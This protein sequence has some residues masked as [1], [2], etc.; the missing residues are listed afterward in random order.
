MTGYQPTNPRLY[1]FLDIPAS[2]H[3]K[4][5]GFSFADGHAELK[6]WRHRDTTLPIIDGTYL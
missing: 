3:G 2:Y 5:G 1:R 4:A 6:K